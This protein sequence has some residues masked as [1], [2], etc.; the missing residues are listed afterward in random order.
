MD[1]YSRYYGIG[2]F[3]I[4]IALSAVLGTQLIMPGVTN[5]TKAINDVKAKKETLV[6]KQ[7]A[8]QNVE[9]KKKQLQNSVINAQKKIYAPADF[10]LG[11]DSLFFTLYT[12]LI[13]MIKSNSIKVK[14]MEYS[15]NP[16]DDQFVTN[17]K[18][19]YFVSEID[20]EL[21]TNYVNFGKFIQ[22]IYQY[23]YYIKI[24]KLNVKPYPKDKKVLIAN[25]SL[26]LYAR[27][28]PEEN[29][30]QE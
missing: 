21:I 25:M 15:Y 10:D 24:L 27:T 16:K 26:R 22:D 17:G 14:S 20:L 4:A 23:P 6:Q 12:D 7:Q 29:N 9:K 11:N 13:E 1:K 3:A 30:D 18:D 5:I 19:V 28:V 8:K 2:V